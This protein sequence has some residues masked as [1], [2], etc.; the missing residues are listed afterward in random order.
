M[1]IMA[2]SG[3][4]LFQLFM[5][6]P[7]HFGTTLACLSFLCSSLNPLIKLLKKR[8]VKSDEINNNNNINKNDNN[9]INKNDINN[10]NNIDN[11]DNEKG[12]EIEEDEESAPFQPVLMV[13]D[14]ILLILN[15][16][17]IGS[18]LSHTSYGLDL[19]QCQKLNSL[20]Q[21]SL[22]NLAQI[23]LAI[24]MVSDFLV[25]MI[26]VVRNGRPIPTHVLLN[27][28]VW[29]ALLFS[30]SR[31]VASSDLLPL[32]CILIHRTFYICF[33]LITTLSKFIRPTPLSMVDYQVYVG[34]VFLA[35]METIVLGQMYQMYQMYRYFSP[36]ECGNKSLRIWT[37]LYTQV[38]LFSSP[39]LYI[40]RTLTV[41]K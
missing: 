9:N 21:V 13:I 5:S 24:L 41:K 26:N 6:S 10:I 14:S 32:T 29:G 31:K 15:V 33:L 35:C 12:K 23:S 40:S 19:F 4:D 22:Q 28:V 37:A 34:F 1:S 27:Q 8:K 7:T 36:S 3:S 11:N 20:E 38:V 30:G 16:T 25:M 17:C 2:W 18:I 39:V